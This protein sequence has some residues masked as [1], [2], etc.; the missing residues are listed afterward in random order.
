VIF[1]LAARRDPETRRASCGRRGA[2]EGPGRPEGSRC[3]HCGLGLEPDGALGLHE[4]SVGKVNTPWNDLEEDWRNHGKE[5]FP[6]LR[7]KYT[8]RPTSMAS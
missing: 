1:W 2:I 7:A 6:I 4:P 3:R 5:I 8:R